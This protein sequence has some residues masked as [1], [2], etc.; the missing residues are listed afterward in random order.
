MDLI[1][2]IIPQIN[3]YCTNTTQA[4]LV[5]KITFYVTTAREFFLLNT[6]GAH[7]TSDQT[8]KEYINFD[9]NGYVCCVENDYLDLRSPVPFE[10]DINWDDG[11][12][13]DHVVA[14]KSGNYYYVRWYSAN[15][16][17]YK[18]FTGNGTDGQ[19]DQMI[20]SFGFK[21]HIFE[22]TKKEHTVTMTFTEGYIDYI[23]CYYINFGKYPL[24]EVPEMK[25]INTN[26]CPCDVVN[27]DRFLYC[28]NLEH[29][30]LRG[31]AST[32]YSKFPDSL[33]QLT[34]LKNLWIDSF[35]NNTDCD[36]NG[37]RNISKLK[38]LQQVTLHGCCDRY[39]KE[40]SDIPSLAYVKITNIF[41]KN[42]AD[43][44]FKKDG[45]TSL[46]SNITQ[47]II[48]SCWSDDQASDNNYCFLPQLDDIEDLSKITSLGNYY[49]V[50]KGNDTVLP[51][52]LDRVFNLK[53]LECA[54]VYGNDSTTSTTIDLG[55]SAFYERAKKYGYNSTYADGDYKGKRNPWYGMRFN[56]YS[57][58]QPVNHRPS[59]TYQ[60]PE[61]FEKGVSDGT[62]GSAMEMI[63]VLVNNYKWTFVI[64]P[65]A[66][67]V[68]TNP[69]ETIKPQSI[70]L[71]NIE[72]I[73]S[74]IT[75]TI[76]YETNPIEVKGRILID[77]GNGNYDVIEGDMN[78]TDILTPDEVT[79]IGF[80]SEDI[81]NEY[82]SE[83]SI[84]LN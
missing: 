56:G 12:D 58:S 78:G 30:G 82:C 8:V 20:A 68:N 10:L 18:K 22:G 80:E 76:D 67:N 34:N 9:P 35:V 83:N 11:T 77:D 63:Y 21:N 81:L 13:I 14:T 72:E 75:D 29:L 71:D 61:G 62:P 84:E 4:T 51:D 44:F 40:M 49:Q 36:T 37:I 5:R 7:P 53:T 19:K 6:H 45:I 47:L 16:D 39:P 52:Y 15:S 46:P 50:P 32:K 17:Y 54:K 57:Q 79:T 60:A 41:S 48:G 43:N 66:G 59:G 42:L 70:S 3:G 74:D 24:I 73:E 26:E 55:I 2:D 38:N 33:W 28:S 31:I 69:G 64:A 65:E 1:G 27:T 25:I 23:Y